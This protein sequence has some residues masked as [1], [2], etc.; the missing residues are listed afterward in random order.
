[1]FVCIHVNFKNI[2]ISEVAVLR[3]FANMLINGLNITHRS[4]NFTVRVR[5]ELW[6]NSH[7]SFV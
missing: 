5:S 4:A 2:L 3:V 1:M 6:K 7:A